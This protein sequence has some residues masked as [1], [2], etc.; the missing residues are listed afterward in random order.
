MF[1]IIMAEFLSRDLISI[2]LCHYFNRFAYPDLFAKECYKVTEALH[3]Y[4]CLLL[5]DSRVSNEQNEYFLNMMESYFSKS[6]GVRDARPEVHYQ[7]GVTPAYIE[8]PRDHCQLYGSLG[9]GNQPLSPCPPELD[10]KWRYFWRVGPRP[11]ITAFPSQNN[12]QVVP[13]EFP[14]WSITMDTWGNKMLDSLLILVEL[15]AVGYDLSPDTFTKLMEVGPHLL[16]P[17]G[18]DLSGAL[19]TVGTVLAGYHYDLNFL[20]IHGKSRFPGLHIW[21]RDGKKL[22]VQV[23]DGCLLVQA[24]KQLEYLT[25]GHVLAGFHEVV[26]T[27][28]TEAVIQ[29]RRTK[30][31]SLWRVSSTCFGHI[32]SDRTL[33]PLPPFAT[34]ETVERYPPVLAGHQVQLELQAISLVK[35]TAE[36][37][38]DKEGT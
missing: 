36:H 34:K 10:P 15:L 17:T 25:A 14:N 8:K 3:V 33:Q 4:G 1:A 23:P 16:A 37:A 22:A 13:D 5:K 7:V 35:S 28:E 27:T 32:A 29:Q 26:V 11:S 2:D 6:D 20:S 30:G 31:E 38:A 24:G 12:E 18:S 19:G 9:P 21:T